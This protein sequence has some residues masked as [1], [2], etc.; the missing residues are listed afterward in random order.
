MSENL[1]LEQSLKIVCISVIICVFALS[2]S[3]FAAG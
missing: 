3:V 2:S 1:T